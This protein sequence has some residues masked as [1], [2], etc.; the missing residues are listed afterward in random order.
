MHSW[1][2]SVGSATFSRR[3]AD[4]GSSL[5]ARRE[6]DGGG[7]RQGLHRRRSGP[8]RRVEPTSEQPPRDATPTRPSLSLRAKL[9]RACRAADREKALWVSGGYGRFRS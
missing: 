8:N 3:P 1:G 5:I 4:F 6:L 2:K 9:K 7:V